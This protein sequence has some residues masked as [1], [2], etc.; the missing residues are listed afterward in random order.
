MLGKQKLKEALPNH[1]AC[2]ANFVAYIINR[3]IDLANHLDEYS[4]ESMVKDGVFGP[5]C[6]IGYGEHIIPITLQFS[7]FKETFT[8]DICNPDNQPEDFA[9]QLVSDMNLYPAMEMTIALSYE[10]RR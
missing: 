4:I 6:G 3:E 10:I 2:Y 1:V 8:W 9:A 7:D 5:G